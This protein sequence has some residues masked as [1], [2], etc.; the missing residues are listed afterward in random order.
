MIE[1]SMFNEQIKYAQTILKGL[2]FEPGREDGYYDFQTELAV[3]AFQKVSGIEATG[4]IDQK[5]A[6]QLES[7]ILEKIKNEKNDVQLL[8]AIQYVARS[9]K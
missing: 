9:T 3:K 8:T 1:G 7:R 2:G 4:K 5:T 6:Q